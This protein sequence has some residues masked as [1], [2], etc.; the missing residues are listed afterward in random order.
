MPIEPYPHAGNR[1]RAFICHASGDKPDARIVYELLKQ[2]GVEPW[3]DEKNLVV[4][5]PWEEQIES[6]VPASDVCMLLLSKGSVSK[7]GYV[8]REIRMALRYADEKPEGAA[9]VLSLL[10]EQCE[11]PTSLKK[12]HYAIRFEQLLETL[13]TRV[14]V[15]KIIHSV[16]I[17]IIDRISLLQRC[18]PSIG[19]SVVQGLARR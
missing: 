12:Y 11:V 9:F 10:L 18:Y 15:I 2:L 6:A 7:E 19:V 17:R 3:L 14:R 4:G 1:L 13:V 8:Q 16:P 5:T